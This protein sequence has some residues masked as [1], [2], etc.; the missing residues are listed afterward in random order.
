MPKIKNVEKRIW[1]VEGFDVRIMSEDG[2]LDVRGD[3]DC[4]IQYPYE[5]ATSDDATVSEWKTNRFKKT[6]ANY[7][8]QVL[9][10]DNNP[11]SGQTK[12]GTVRDSYE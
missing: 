2:Q 3:K 7:E 4:P 1:E 8:V 10:A 5:R 12:I 6:F 9:K 11:V